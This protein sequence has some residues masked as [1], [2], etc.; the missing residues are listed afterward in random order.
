[1]FFNFLWKSIMG[2][3]YII[4][5]FLVF[6]IFFQVKYYQRSLL[7]DRFFIIFLIVSFFT[8][9]LVIPLLLINIFLPFVFGKSKKYIL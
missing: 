9:E 5:N 1:M 7:K 6:I 8:F 2:Y 4:L 3:L